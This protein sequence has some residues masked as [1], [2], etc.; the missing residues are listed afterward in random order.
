MPRTL[1]LTALRSFV[2][3]A[4][5]GGVTR[6]AQQL[7]LTQSAV[8]MQLKR[9]EEFVGLNL[10]DRS[11]R[12]IG[13]TPEGE[14]L[15]LYA[16]RMLALNDEAWGRLTNSD[17]EGDLRIGA[18]YDVIYPNVPGV[19]QRFAVE[20]PRVRVQMRDMP[21]KD[22]LREF[23]GGALDLILTTEAGVQPG[24][25]T[26]TQE[27]LAWIG[28]AGGQAWRSRP[29]PIAVVTFCVFRRLTIAALDAAGLEW[30]VVAESESSRAV[31]ASVSADLAIQSALAGTVTPHHEII[32][33]GG[34][35]PPLPVYN[36]NMYVTEGP[37]ADLA[38][39]LA[40][41]M[42]TAFCGGIRHA[43]E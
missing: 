11:A 13:L 17:F 26:L 16:R 22:L 29:V 3:V 42:R 27:Q 7:N 5:A 14:Q 28:A 37:S 15:L 32:R 2:G 4:D 6:A 18:P 31:D 24:G 19:L 23:A 43:A 38:A 25:E 10:L 33:H 8:S 30:R 34:A 40:D 41:L 9:L 12:T 39:R 1:D 20:Y 36:I 35:L 21:S